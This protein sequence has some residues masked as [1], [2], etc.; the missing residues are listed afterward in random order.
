MVKKVNVLLLTEPQ[1]NESASPGS[2]DHLEMVR[3]RNGSL[4]PALDENCAPSLD[5]SY[6]IRC[7]S[8]TTVFGKLNKVQEKD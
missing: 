1:I 2:H 7:L 4:K 8:I 3:H 6:A 5:S